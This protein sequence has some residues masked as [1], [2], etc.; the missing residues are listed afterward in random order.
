MEVE[1]ERAEEWSDIIELAVATDW[2]ELRAEGV[3]D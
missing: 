3:R 2:T 1:R